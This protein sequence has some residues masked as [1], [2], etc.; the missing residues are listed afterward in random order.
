[1]NENKKGLS[2]VIELYFR[3]LN[4]LDCRPNDKYDSDSLMYL[5]TFYDCMQEILGT[6]KEAILF[7]KKYEIIKNK[8]L[9]DIENCEEIF[10]EFED[11]VSK[12]K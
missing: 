7:L 9:N 4:G 3:N 2:L 11:L 1:M 8:K 5:G 10:K 12:I 6:S